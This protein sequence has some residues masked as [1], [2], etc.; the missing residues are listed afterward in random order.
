MNTKDTTNAELELNQDT[1]GAEPSEQ[2]DTW[3]SAEHQTKL[4]DLFFEKPKLNPQNPEDRADWIVS[5]VFRK[6]VSGNADWTIN[7]DLIPKEF[8]WTKDKIRQNYFRENPKEQEERINALVQSALE[9]HLN[10]Q[11]QATYSQQVNEFL[12]DDKVDDEVKELVAQ[13][14]DTL[15][16]WWLSPELALQT[17]KEIVI[18][19]GK[20]PKSFATSLH[21]WRVPTITKV[22]TITESEYAKLPQ[23]EYNNASDLVKEGKLKVVSS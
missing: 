2:D 7:L 1:N 22:P 6:Y 23:A 10:S 18:W 13:K 5:D 15:R 20:K 19:Q 3:T 8:A 4:K 21:V 11:K 9:K 14:A 16:K 17:A 12:S